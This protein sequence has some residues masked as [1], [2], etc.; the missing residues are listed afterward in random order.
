M[1]FPSGEIEQ[2]LDDPDAGFELSNKTIKFYSL[3][4]GLVNFLMP[5]HE[6]TTKGAILESIEKQIEDIKEKKEEGGKYSERVFE[7]E[8]VRWLND[9]GPRHIKTVIKR[10]RD[11]LKGDA[12]MT[13]REVFCLLSAIHLHDLGN[14]YGR[15]IILP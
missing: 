8:K 1:E 6:E 12:Q 15:A 3:Y 11:L 5:K 10:A 9:H 13:F 4:D 2:W 14:F 7:L